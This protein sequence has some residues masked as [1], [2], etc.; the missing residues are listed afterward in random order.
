VVLDSRKHATLGRLP[1]LPEQSEPDPR[2][3]RPTHPMTVLL[4][5]SVVHNGFLLTSGMGLESGCHATCPYE[6][7]R[8]GKA[9]H[10]AMVYPLN[11]LTAEG[12]AIR[13]GYIDDRN[14]LARG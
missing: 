12:T 1:A 14:T 5:G 4:P 2:L 11:L 9:A 8:T 13:K 6:S 10:D 3:A 7:C